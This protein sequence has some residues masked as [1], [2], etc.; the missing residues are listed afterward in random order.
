MRTQ[1]NSTKCR[2]FYDLWKEDSNS[3]IQLDLYTQVQNNAGVEVSD[4]S[5]QCSQCSQETVMVI[6]VCRSLHD[7]IRTQ[8]ILHY[9]R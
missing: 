1:W 9:K 2:N 7:Q 5:A 4:Y 8:G 3:V 6:L